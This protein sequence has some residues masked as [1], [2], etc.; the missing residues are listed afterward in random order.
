LA[1]MLVSLLQRE[2]DRAGLRGSIPEILDELGRIREITVLYP[3]GQPG[4]KPTLHT[5]LSEM[6]ERQRELFTALGL[7]RY[8]A[9]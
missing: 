9:P 1:L 4:Q 8:R 3:A 5:T 6:N 2:L 7:D